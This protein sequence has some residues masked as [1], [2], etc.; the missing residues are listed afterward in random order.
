MKTLTIEG[1]KQEGRGSAKARR[2]RRA[3]HVTC[4]LYGQSGNLN[5]YAPITAFKN[6]VYTPEFHTVTISVEG[7]EF[8]AILKD[9]QFDPVTDRL[10][11]VDFL[12]LHPEK[13]VIIDI[14]VKLEGTPVGTREGG[15]L[16]QKLRALRIKALPVHFVEHLSVNVE[17]LSVGKAVRV[18]ELSFANIEILTAGNLPVAS[19]NIPRVEKEETPVAAAAAVPA[20]GAAAAAPAADAKAAPEKEGKKK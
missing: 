11:H 17:A 10:N 1:Q 8:L 15:R 12:E 16:T 5:F 9:L 18:N 6:L 3:G 14:P 4:N 7:K 2:I 13:K 20:E 19:V